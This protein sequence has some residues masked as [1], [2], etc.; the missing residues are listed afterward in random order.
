ML[1]S[2][3]W[4]RVS[5]HLLPLLVPGL[6]ALSACGPESNPSTPSS[7]TSGNTGNLG[8]LTLPGNQSSSSPRPITSPSPSASPTTASPTVE[9][10]SNVMVWE[11]RPAGQTQPVSYLTGTVH[12]PFA[13]NYTLPASFV[14]QLNASKAFY[15]EADVDAISQLTQSIANQAIDANGDLQA[16]LGDNYFQRLL[17]RMTAANLALPSEVL[18]RL[19]P[20]YINLLIASPPGQSSDPNTIMDLVLR[21]R[22]IDANIKVNYLESAAAQIEALQNISETE[23]LRLIKV[24]LD[25]GV[26]KLIS[27]RK[28]VFDLYN[29]GNIAGLEQAEAE[30]RVESA[31]YFEQLLRKRNQ[32]WLSLLTPQLQKESTF[33]AVGALHMAGPEGLVQQLQ[34]SGFEVKAITYP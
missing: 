32:S 2:E 23:L 5:R 18:K 3:K 20:W 31:E 33:V 10:V 29:Q 4:R 19:K 1:L 34:S 30:A 26:E 8:N 6:L 7:P 17:T 15:M 11:V 13:S 9:A 22:A 27:E 14:Q 12:A 21:K 25:Q 28:R 16:T 24:N